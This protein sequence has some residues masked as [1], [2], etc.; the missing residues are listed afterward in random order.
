M[1]NSMAIPTAVM[2]CCL[3]IPGSPQAEE[4]PSLYVGPDDRP[5]I[6]ERIGR[7]PFDGW[8][9]AIRAGAQAGLSFD[10]AAHPDHHS[11]APVARDLAFTTW[12]DDDSIYV[13]KAVEILSTIDPEAGWGEGHRA[14]ASALAYAEAY[15]FLAGSGLLAPAEDAI[16]RDR[17]LETISRMDR[18]PVIEAI[19][20]NWKIRYFSGAATLCLALEDGNSNHGPAQVSD[21]RRN[22]LDRVLQTIVLQEVDGAW[23]EGSHYL[24]YSAS[25]YIRLFLAWERLFGTRFLKAKA[26][27]RAH[28]FVVGWAL[29]QGLTPNVDDAR[30]ADFPSGLIAPYQSHPEFH[31]WSAARDGRWIESADLRVVSICAH[32][33]A[34]PGAP[35]TWNPDLF[36]PKAGVAIFRSGW[37]PDD[38]HLMIL[39]EHRDA[40]ALGLRHE[41]ADGTSFTLWK[42]RV[43]LLLD[44]GYHSW[45]ERDLV[46]GPE[47]HN[48]ILVDGKGPA[49]PTALRPTQGVDA[50]LSDWVDEDT[51]GSVTVSTS[52]HRTEIVRNV[53]HIRHDWITLIDDLATGAT[54]RYRTFTHLLHGN[55]EERLGTFESQPLGGRWFAED[56]ELVAEV[57]AP[58]G[59]TLETARDIHS[60]A[61][62]DTIGHT[63]LRSSMDGWYTRFIVTLTYGPRGNLQVPRVVRGEAGVALW[64]PQGHGLDVLCVAEQAGAGFSV[65]VPSVGSVESPADQIY[66]R[67][68]DG[69][70]MDAVALAGPCI[71]K[72]NGAPR[73]VRRSP[74]PAP[75]TP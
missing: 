32:P 31:L 44:G 43:P 70:V 38:S 20:N 27:T 56:L 11:R 46:A 6:M 26:L 49:E 3:S 5:W 4:H 69:E 68:R 12:I 15:D 9:N 29:P 53:T 55:G 50:W 17:L 39:G 54:F 40:R 7:A 61:Y 18:N 67:V 57:A 63:V 64:R 21:W 72:V 2:A 22:S 60:F 16:I 75:S 8:W 14:G 52:H 74:A 1:K 28:D 62:G 19:P 34:A 10:V 47:H 13:A 65:E 35:P 48:L 41:H 24:N 23:A 45:E 36:R 42:G 66:L 59:V 71:L 51:L 30:L 58:L 33:E 73:A 37:T 25:T